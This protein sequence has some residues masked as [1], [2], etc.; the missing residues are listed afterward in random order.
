MW[1]DFVGS[2]CW[3][4]VGSRVVAVSNSRQFAADSKAVVGKDSDF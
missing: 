1:G 2:A 4:I 3:K